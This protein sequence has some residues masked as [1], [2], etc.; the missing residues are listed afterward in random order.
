MSS[1]AK[2]IGEAIG[3]T[4]PATLALVE[5]LMRADRTALDGLTRPAFIRAARDTYA[6]AAMLAAA[7]ELG[8]Y[9]EAL[10]LT[11]PTALYI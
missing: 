11:T 6:D 8:M 5:E 10:G 4:D 7:G 2:L 3:T 9:C 1:Y